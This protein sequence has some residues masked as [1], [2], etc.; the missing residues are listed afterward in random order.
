MVQMSRQTSRTAQSF[1]HLAKRP[2][3][4]QQVLLRLFGLLHDLAM[5]SLAESLCMDSSETVVPLLF[6]KNCEHWHC[7]A[8]LFPQTTANGVES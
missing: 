8:Q 7:N 5:L 2:E 4:L 3:M 1:F 6:G